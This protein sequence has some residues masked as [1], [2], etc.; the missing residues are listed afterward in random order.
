MDAGKGFTCLVLLCTAPLVLGSFT[1]NESTTECTTLMS[2]DEEPESTEPTTLNDTT[3]VAVTS[4]RRTTKAPTCYYTAVLN[5][6][7]KTMQIG[8]LQECGLRKTP[9]KDGI[10]C[11][12]VVRDA[13]LYM[14]EELLYLCP[15]G[16]CQ[17]GT[18][19]PSGLDLKCWKSYPE[20]FE[21]IFGPFR[22]P[23]ILM[24]TTPRTTTT[25]AATTT[26]STTTEPANITSS[27]E[28]TNATSE[29]AE[30]M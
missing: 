7:K 13:L 21:R 20:I 29:Q 25:T 18:C 28:A 27:S 15:I 12:D 22:R 5:T 30:E 6:P 3:T 19:I 26:T 10:E 14:Q 11:I 23:R 1:G 16:L 2:V 9:L 4:T 17:N 24:S 8:C